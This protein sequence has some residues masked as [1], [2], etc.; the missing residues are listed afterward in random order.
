MITDAFP[1]TQVESAPAGIQ[2]LLKQ[3]NRVFNRGLTKLMGRKY[4]P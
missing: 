2:S 3:Q 4:L 1:D